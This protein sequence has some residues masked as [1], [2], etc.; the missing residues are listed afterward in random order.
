MN[1]FKQQPVQERPSYVLT[2]R[3]PASVGD[4]LLGRIVADF[5]S[6]LDEY[7]PEDPRPALIAGTLEIVDTDFSSLFSVSRNKLAAAKISQ[8]LHIDVES[9]LKN[10]SSIKSSYVRTRTLPQ[11]REVLAALLKKHATDIIKLLRDN[12]GKA[13]MAVGFKSCVDGEIGKAR[14]YTNK[15]S[16]RI[17]A[18]VGAM[19]SAVSQGT[20]NLGD[21][22]N[23]GLDVQRSREE[24]LTTRATMVGEQIF[25][26]RYRALSLSKRAGG[27][28]AD[29]GDILRVKFENGVYSYSERV[30]TFVDDESD[31]E[32]DDSGNEE[33]TLG[34]EWAVDREAE[35]M[36]ESEFD[37]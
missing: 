6:P 33:V 19:V 29:Y 28:E 16:V 10:E 15:K 31:D 34:G 18:P 30:G 36:I 20:V 14:L 13:Y 27:P 32:N 24:Q 25:A 22:A 21:Q 35:N 4:A 8:I 2:D 7:K 11:H 37:E 23:V 1:P 3:L 17:E 9:L 5:L 26:V 12:K